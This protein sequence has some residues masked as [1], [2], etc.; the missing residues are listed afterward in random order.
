MSE[1]LPWPRLTPPATVPGIDPPYNLASACAYCR[2]FSVASPQTEHLICECETAC[3]APRC[4]AA[5]PH[6]DKCPTCPAVVGTP[7]YPSCTIYGEVVIEPNRGEPWD[8]VRPADTRWTT[9]RCP[10]V[11]VRHRGREG[12]LPG[13]ARSTWV[14][15]TEPP[16]HR[17]PH[18]HAWCAAFADPGVS[19]S[20]IQPFTPPASTG[21]GWHT[22][23][24]WAEWLD[25]AAWLDALPRRLPGVSP[26]G[27]FQD[28]DRQRADQYVATL[29]NRLT[30]GVPR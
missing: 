7:H 22:V 20:L 1:P 25:A 27:V 5:L 30:A 19:V 28:L 12:H 18:V 11:L 4:I 10:A 24:G 23:R 21:T 15:P 17:D 14:T 29:A 13:C 9:C 16:A 8:V 26:L 2:A 6:P 3:G